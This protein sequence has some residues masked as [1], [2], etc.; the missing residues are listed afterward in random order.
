MSS[1]NN[2]DPVMVSTTA[3]NEDVATCQQLARN[4]WFD[5]Y[6]GGEKVEFEENPVS[7]PSKQGV[8]VCLMVQWKKNFDFDGTTLKIDMNQPNVK[9][10]LCRLANLGTRYRAYFNHGVYVVTWQFV[11]IGNEQTFRAGDQ[12]NSMQGEDLRPAH[13]PQ[14]AINDV[15][16]IEPVD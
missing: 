1:S 6:F 5:G 9:R 16:Y 8:S 13:I 15:G 10:L 12:H 11:K 7:I 4:S 2:L 3:P 14:P